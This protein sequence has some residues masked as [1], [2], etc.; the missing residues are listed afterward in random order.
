MKRRFQ[1]TVPGIF[2][3]M[4]GANHFVMPGF[5]LPLIPDYLPWPIFLNAISGVLELAIGLGFFFSSSR[6]WAGLG[7]LLLMTFFIPSHVYFITTGGCVADGL[8]VPLWVA[9]VRL[10]IIHPILMGFGWWIWRSR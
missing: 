3:L 9:W 6:K 2:F 7:M 8:C 5:Y 1:S 10:L 4:A